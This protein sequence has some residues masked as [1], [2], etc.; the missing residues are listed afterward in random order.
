MKNLRDKELSYKE[1]AD[2]IGLSRHAIRTNL[3]KSYGHDLVDRPMTRVEKALFEE[4]TLG[5]QGLSTRI[6]AAKTGIGKST[7]AKYLKKPLSHKLVRSNSIAL[8]CTPS[9]DH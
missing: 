2:Q 7:V 1:I 3:I 9:S 8:N 5:N 6:I 4:M